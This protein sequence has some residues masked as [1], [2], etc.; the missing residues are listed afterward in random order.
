MATSPPTPNLGLTLWDKGSDTYNHSELANNFVK[1]DRHDHSPGRGNPISTNGLKDNIITTPKIVDGAVTPSKIPDNSIGIE[2]LTDDSVSSAEIVNGSVGT[3]EIADGSVTG[4]KLALDV[5]PLGIIVPWY[6][7]DANA[8]IPQGW[9]LP[10]GQDWSTVPNDLGLSSGKLPDLRNKFILGGATVGTGSGP[11]SP[12]SP[13]S[14]GGSN[15]INLNHK[16]RVPEHQHNI[17]SHDHGIATQ[18]AHSHRFW[19]TNYDGNGNPVG[20]FLTALYQRTVGV[21]SSAGSRQAAFIPNLNARAV[22]ADGSEAVPSPMG[23]DEYADGSA[24]NHGG[25]TGGSGP[26]S[27]TGIAVDTEYSMDGATDHRP[28]FIGLLHIMKVKV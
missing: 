18:A 11:Y 4:R 12:P 10:E 23:P 7:A 16:H 24:H 13:G 25:R 27:T 22:Q 28:N 9:V 15:L 20:N 19:S 3:N 1:I 2:K 6:R 5:L 21:R 14:T 26:L 8:P 17:P